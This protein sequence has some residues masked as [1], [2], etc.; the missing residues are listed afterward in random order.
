M[1]FMTQKNINH[2]ASSIAHEQY[3]ISDLTVGLVAGR[4]MACKN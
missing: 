2:L 1:L 4:H 3:A